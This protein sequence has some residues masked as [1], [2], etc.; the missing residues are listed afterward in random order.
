MTTWHILTGEYPPQTGGVSDYTQLIAESLVR[1]GE[2]VHIWAPECIGELECIGEMPR[3]PGVKVHRLPGVFG[4]QALR[5]LDAF[6]HNQPQPF[7]LLVQYVPHMYGLKGMNL[8]LCLWLLR[9]KHVRPWIMFHEVA[10]P[11]E[12]QQSLRHQLLAVVQ[13]LMASL[14]VRA[15]DLIF[16]SIP[17]WQL[18]LQSLAPKFPQIIW[19][20]VPS[21]VSLTAEPESVRSIREQICP[22]PS[23]Q[24]VGHFSTYGA[25]IATTLIDLI[26]FVLHEYDRKILLIG[27]ESFRFRDLFLAQYSQFQDRVIATGELNPSAI[28]AHLRACDLLIQPYPDGVSS[29]RTSLMAGLA[30]GLPIVTSEGALT[31]PIWRDEKLVAV[32]PIHDLAYFRATVHA[33]LQDEPARQEL[34]QRAKVGYAKWFSLDRTIATLRECDQQH[35]SRRLAVRAVLPRIAFV[36]NGAPCSAMGHRARAFA[37]RL[38]SEFAIQL[39]YRTGDKLS[40]L[41]QITKGLARCRP[42][43]IYVFDMAWSGVGAGLIHRLRPGMRLVI[44]TGDAI[45]ELARSMGRSRVGITLTYMLER[46]SLSGADCIVVRGSVHHELLRARRIRVEFI[47]DG[48]ELDLFSPKDI[49]R[50]FSGELT[51]GLVG[52][53]IWSERLKTCYGLELVETLRRLRRRPVRGVMIGSGSGIEVLQRYCQEHGLTDRIEFLGHVPYDQ[54]PEQLAR[55]DVCLSTQTN[56]LPGQVRTTGKLPLYLAAGKYIL[57]SRVGEAAR[58]LPEEMLVEYHGTSDPDYPARL[59]ERLEVLCD[60]PEYLARGLDNVALARQHFDYDLLAERMGKLLHSLLL[61]L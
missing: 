31:E 30:L 34:G 40:S 23:T 49:S 14:L 53:S 19:L 35:D 2:E 48:V 12:W 21:N 6:L 20:P 1:T 47:P 60:H 8:P 44:D 32:A 58:I 28:A 45:T 46:V 51:I 9:Q 4:R 43:L 37:S 54:L 22:N 17:H 57:A 33:L 55:I 52:S 13:R 10:Y 16:V 24:L 41:F 18:I 7:R 25:A 26:P 11:W 36:V 27:R 39:L 59:A 5:K 61:D 42:R 50:K 38:Q 56:D 15:A 29:R 3:V